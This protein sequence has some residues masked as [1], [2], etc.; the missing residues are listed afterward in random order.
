MANIG[1]PYPTG[2]AP[3]DTMVWIP[4]W[5]KHR[6]SYLPWYRSSNKVNG[7]NRSCQSD[8]L[9]WWYEDLE[10]CEDHCRKLN[11]Q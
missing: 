5:E 11:N 4:F 3:A 2:K 6:Q 8:E 1:H 10:D 7:H 9:I